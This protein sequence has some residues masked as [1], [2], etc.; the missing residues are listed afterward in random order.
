MKPKL[1]CQLCK[2]CSEGGGEA[3]CSDP[4]L[5]LPSSGISAR[6][7]IPV[8][9][10]AK[11]ASVRPQIFEAQMT[12]RSRFCFQRSYK[13]MHSQTECISRALRNMLDAGW[14]LGWTLV[15]G[16]CSSRQ[17]RCKGKLVEASL[18]K[19]TTKEVG[20]HQYRLHFEFTISFC[21]SFI[22]TRHA[23]T[24]HSPSRQGREDLLV[25]EDWQK[26]HYRDDG[27]QW[28]NSER[29]LGQRKNVSC[30][31]PD[32]HGLLRF[33]PGPLLLVRVT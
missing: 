29:S 18:C 15:C 8:R 10:L 3:C 22:Q 11:A 2:S 25:L 4:A 19:H 23:I 20:L 32:R 13:I 21:C 27:E 33:W 14:M 9:T 7:E 31:V 30:L 26:L 5:R 24:K 12:I 28:F 16:G 6:P 17:S 1:C